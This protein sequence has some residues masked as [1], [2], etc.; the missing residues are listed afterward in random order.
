MIQPIPHRDSEPLQM[1][2]AEFESICQRAAR[3]AV[4][5]NAKLGFP[6]VFSE[7]GKIVHW[8]PERVLAEFGVPA[9]VSID[10]PGIQ[11]TSV[12]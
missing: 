6:A 7:N 4:I 3:E 8:S 10:A 1:S 11:P 2:P 9:P 5:R 12:R